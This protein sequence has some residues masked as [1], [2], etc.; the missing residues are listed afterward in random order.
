MAKMMT[1]NQKKNTMMPGI[2]YPPT[3]LALATT[4]SYP[5]PPDLFRGGGL[6]TKQM[7]AVTPCPANGGRLN[8][9]EIVSARS[10]GGVERAKDR[11]V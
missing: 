1:T 3:V 9:A 7:G 4:A 2:A 5:P 6:T 11:R 10:T 8:R